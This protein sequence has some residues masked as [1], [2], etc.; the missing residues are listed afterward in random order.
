MTVKESAAENSAGGG[1]DAVE[2][3][4][5]SAERFVIVLVVA[6][7]LLAITWRIAESSNL[8]STIPIIG[9][10]LILV[11]IMVEVL[12]IERHRHHK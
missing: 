10:G 1:L 7:M 8:G 6:I 4:V 12:L 3:W 2:R 5:K 11:Y 9:I